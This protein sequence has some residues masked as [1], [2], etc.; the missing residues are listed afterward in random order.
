MTKIRFFLGMAEG[1]HWKF[2]YKVYYTTKHIFSQNYHTS[3]I[4][5]KYIK[6]SGFAT[7]HVVVSVR[8]PTT[9]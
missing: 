2:D 8:K 7:T 9:Y 1:K 4:I 6:T 3:Q 5:I